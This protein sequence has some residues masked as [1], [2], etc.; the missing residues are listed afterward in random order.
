MDAMRPRFHSVLSDVR[1]QRMHWRSWGGATAFGV[2]YV[3]HTDYAP[4]G[5]GGY[6]R[7]DQMARA[8]FHLSRVTYCDD[9]TLIY[10]HLLV[11]TLQHSSG[12]RRYTN[13]DYDC[14]GGNGIG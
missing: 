9:G 2:G 7:Y 1:F 3:G 14:G 5:H 13:F 12:L 4:N 8:T 11:H 10:A 6:R